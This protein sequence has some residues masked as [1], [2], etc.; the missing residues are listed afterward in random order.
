[1][2]DLDI[3][4]SRPGQ[5]RL[6]HLTVEL[7]RT[8]RSLCIELWKKEGLERSSI[9][10]MYRSALSVAANVR[11]AQFAES[12]RDFIHKL[13]IAEKE[14]AEFSYWLGVLH[15]P[16]Q[17]IP[18]DQGTQLLDTTRQVGKLLASIITSL[19]RKDTS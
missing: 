6:Q 4:H 17:I 18:S 2:E 5:G 12:T 7:A 19:K 1:M 15:H 11:E 9:S 16:P 14:L 3:I 13:K 10:Q 8:V